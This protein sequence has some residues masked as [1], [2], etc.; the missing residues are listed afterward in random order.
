[1]N[2]EK[3]LKLLRKALSTLPRREVNERVNFY[4]EMID[5]RMEEGLSEEE[6]LA[7]VG[8]VEEIA[9]Q[10]LAEAD[11][12]IRGKSGRRLRAWEIVLLAL[13]SPLWIALLAAAF[14]VVISLLAALWSV[15]VS[16]WSVFASLAGS[17]FGMIVCGVVLAITGE[18]LMGAVML[19][20]A[21]VCA[22]LAIFAF[23]GCKAATKGAVFL[24]KWTVIGIIRFFKRKGEA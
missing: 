7:R 10:I 24:S 12:E 18:W 19:G 16:F 3:F 2:K 23:F 5:D 6:A 11:V 15:I 21:M 9:R 4:G 13:G 14:A 20:V 1:M 8:S 17:A 22:G